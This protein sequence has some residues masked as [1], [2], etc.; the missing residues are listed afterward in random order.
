MATVYQSS[1]QAAPPRGGLLRRWWSALTAPFRARARERAVAAYL[2]ELAEGREPPALSGSGELERAARHLAETL[3]RRSEEDIDTAVTVSRRVADSV[4]AASG[5]RLNVTYTAEQVQS[6]AAAAEELSASVESISGHAK[7]VA[8]ET[9]HAREAVGQAQSAGREADRAMA[10]IGAKTQQ[11]TERVEALSRASEE[12]GKAVEAIQQIA[13][14][15]NILALNASVE[16]ARAGEAGQGFGVV[17]QEVRKLANQSKDASVDISRRIGDLQQE[18]EQIGTVQREMGEAVEQGQLAIQR[19]GEQIEDMNSRMQ[20]VAD[21]V[22]E[23]AEQL[24]Q[25]R[26]A[27]NEVAESINGISERTDRSTRELESV[28][29]AMA[30]GHEAVQH[31]IQRLEQLPI[32]CLSLHQSRNDHILWKRRIASMLAGR[33]RVDPGELADHHQCRLG[34]WY[35]HVADRQLLEHPDF[36]ALAEPHAGVHRHGKAAADRYN[37]GDIDAAKQELDHLAES[38]D[39]VLHRLER[40]IAD[41]ER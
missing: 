31:Q 19:S 25:Q 35:D 21:R 5:M 6:I 3:G 37:A 36:K 8:E 41:W 23:V 26:T 14:R 27:V 20:T 17:A 33:E 24:N 1:F 28:L 13:S 15:T 12:I 10:A 34:R 29:D 39:H 22:H 4:M 2:V 9:D 38:S 11:S 30:G 7:E 32:P 40:L 18:M 16:A